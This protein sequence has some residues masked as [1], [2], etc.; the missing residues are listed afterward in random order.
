MDKN[1][2]LFNPVNMLKGEKE[3]SCEINFRIWSV[4]KKYLFM[5]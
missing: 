1:D 3:L 4:L 5:G 2:T